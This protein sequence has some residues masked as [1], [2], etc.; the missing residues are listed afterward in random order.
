ME[1]NNE[2]KFNARLTNASEFITNGEAYQI[3]PEGIDVTQINLPRGVEYVKREKFLYSIG[4]TFL[5]LNPEASFDLVYGFISSVNSI[6]AVIE[7]PVSIEGVTRVCSQVFNKRDKEG[8]I[9]LKANKTR[10]IIFNDDSN[11]SRQ[12]KLEIQN[13]EMGNLKKQKTM[14]TIY[15]AIE[16]WD[17]PTKIT[18]KGIVEVVG[19]SE[20]TVKTYWPE[21]KSF[22]KTLND[23]IKN[24]TVITNQNEEVIPEVVEEKTIQPE[25]A[26]EIKIDTQI[27]EIL[28]NK[29]NEYIFRQRTHSG[30]MISAINNGSI[31]SIEMFETRIKLL[32]PRLK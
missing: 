15:Q 9:I 1:N 29:L 25:P 2:K 10:K 32:D 17:Q 31:N 11:L 8:E 3:F 16:A 18:I 27:V 26:N 4:E 7:R 28:I 21:F 13:R 22:V 19:M 6:K 12:E 20:R 14:D 5:G 23:D 30:M 24:K